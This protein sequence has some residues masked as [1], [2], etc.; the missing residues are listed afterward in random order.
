MIETEYWLAQ[1]EEFILSGEVL[2]ELLQATLAKGLPF[3]FEAKGFSMAPFIKGGDVL[4]VSP[5]CNSPITIGKPVAFIHPLTK[6]LAI[7]RV[8]ARNGQR[9]LIKGDNVFKVDGLVSQ[10]NILGY[11][12][13]IERNAKTISFGFGRERFIIAF[14]SRMRILNFILCSWRQL[15]PYSIRK[16]IIS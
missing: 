14:L 5:L 11:V 4:T 9:Y 7:H 2:V 8:I 6:H 10:E 13:V 15:I 16:R 12:S 1:K 3:R